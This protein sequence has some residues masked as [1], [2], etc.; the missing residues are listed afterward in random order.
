MSDASSTLTVRI[1]SA[2]EAARDGDHQATAL[3]L[4]QYTGLIRRTLHERLG[5]QLGKTRDI[6]DLEQDVAIR[7]MRSLSKHE[8]RGR[9]AFQQW[10]RL[11]ARGE[12]VDQ[13]R[14]VQA[15]KRGGNAPHS[16]LTE[17]MVSAERPG[18]ET[19]AEQARQLAWL[20]SKLDALPFNHAQA[21]ILSVV[22]HSY[23]E[24]GDMLGV[25]AEAARKLVTRGKKKLLDTE[26]S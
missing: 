4:N 5:D 20:Q 12:I 8:W 25:S 3:I 23:P 19:Q 14:E 10:L 2:F 18:L 7:L 6:D 16:P 17:E 15:L 26:T 13:L 11:L 1:A 22:G 21:I 9:K 24:I